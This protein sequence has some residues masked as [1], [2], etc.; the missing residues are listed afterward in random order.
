MRQPC[1]Y[2]ARELK[3][4]S[5]NTEYEYLGWFPARPVGHNVWSWATRWKVAF[6]VLI[7]KFDA[8]DWQERY[9]EKK[10]RKYQ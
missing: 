3:E 2:T 9:A 7:G 10:K 1:I 6:A 4:W 5:I 8:V